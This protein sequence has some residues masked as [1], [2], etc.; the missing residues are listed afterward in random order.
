[1]TYEQA[2]NLKPNTTLY[3]KG[4]DEIF[5]V[6]GIDVVEKDRAVWVVGFEHDGLKKRHHKTLKLKKSSK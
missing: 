5:R 6:D 3:V 1:M 4:T 2:L